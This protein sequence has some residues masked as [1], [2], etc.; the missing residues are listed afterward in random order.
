MVKGTKWK[1]KNKNV[2]GNDRANDNAHIEEIQ[3]D[4]AAA[5]GLLE[6]P[7]T[8]SGTVGEESKSPAALP[9]S[10]APA[11]GEDAHGSAL[12]ALLAAQVKPAAVSAG[13]QQSAGEQAVPQ[14]SAEVAAPVLQQVRLTEQEQIDLRNNTYAADAKKLHAEAE[15]ARLREEQDRMDYDQAAYYEA[16]GQQRTRPGVGCGLFD[17]DLTGTDLRADRWGRNYRDVDPQGQK[18]WT[19]ETE[20]TWEQNLASSRKA[21][22]EQGDT[23]RLFNARWQGQE[24]SKDSVVKALAKTLE[25]IGDVDVPHCSQRCLTAWGWHQISRRRWRVQVVGVMCPSE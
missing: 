7:E 2:V 14:D 23:Y 13:V 4:V 11:V 9:P 22:Q 5:A 10:P 8:G 16:G 12:A 21:A 3:R 15:R 25:P 20:N 17:S 1:N 6:V 19:F 18:R 24:L